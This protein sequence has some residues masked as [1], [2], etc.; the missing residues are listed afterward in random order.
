MKRALSLFLILCLAL[1]LAGCMSPEE[2]QARKEALNALS[3]GES[4]YSLSTGAT[5]DTMEVFNEKNIVVAVAGITGTPEDPRLKLAVR[6][7][8]RKAISILVRRL[9]ING[10]E[11]DAL[12]D[13]EQIEPH[14][15]TMGT[16]ESFDDVT[17]CGITDVETVELEFEI[18]DEDYNTLAGVSC[19]STTSAGDGLEEDFTPPEGVTLLDQDGVLVRA[20]G[21]HSSDS[22][23]WLILYLENTTNR[24][25]AITAERA[26]C[27]GEPVELW[28][29]ERVSPGCRRMVYEWIY[30]ED[31][32]QNLMMSDQDELSFQ[33]E[34][35]D[36]ETGIYIQDTQVSLSPDQF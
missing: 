21:L 8:S 4:E 23:S 19:Y 36:W 6:N 9:V 15:V 7:G 11:L 3:G 5:M 2:R 24:D 17:L 22:G 14:S 28:L 13:M 10:W 27:N 20:T 34:V 29:Y 30:T 33:L 35:E 1:C 12:S 26:R 18:Y 25:V 31:D 32:Y 16:V